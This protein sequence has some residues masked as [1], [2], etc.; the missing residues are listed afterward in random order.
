MPN[1]TNGS[2]Q[3]VR[4][5]TEIKGSLEREM[6]G[7]RE[8]ISTRFDAQAARL[9]R[10]GGFIRSGSVWSSRMDQWPER[11]DTLIEQRDRQIAE[12][13]ERL[14]KLEGER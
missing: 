12:I 1:D 4:L 14:R 8:V 7:L 2:E 5:L 11:I 6:T 10:Q 13:P 3:I 9:D